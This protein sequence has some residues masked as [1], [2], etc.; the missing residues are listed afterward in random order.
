VVVVIVGGLVLGRGRLALFETGG[1]DSPAAA[2][3][4]PRHRRG[5]GD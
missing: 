2:T 3:H 4:H 5:R 1:G